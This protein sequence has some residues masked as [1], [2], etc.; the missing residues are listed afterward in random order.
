MDS[1]RYRQ[2]TRL[3]ISVFILKKGEHC[4]RSGLVYQA[5]NDVSYHRILLSEKLKTS[6]N[7]HLGISRSLLNDP[8]RHAIVEVYNDI[9]N[10][11]DLVMVIVHLPKL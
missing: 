3:Y 5:S 2:L 8:S 11:L 9:F 7:P 10:L 4:R 6:R 1:K